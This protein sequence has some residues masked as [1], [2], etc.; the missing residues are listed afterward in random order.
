[1]DLFFV[2]SGFL[3]TRILLYTRGTPEYFKNFYGRRS[4]RIFPLYFGALF[5]VFVVTPWLTGGPV[6][7]LRQQLWYWFY[8]N[9]IAYTFNITAPGPNHFWSL[10]VEEHFYLVWPLLVALLPLGKLKRAAFG[11]IAVAVLTRILLLQADYGVFY[12][13]LSRVDALSAGCLL[14]V[15]ERERSLGTK[16]RAFAYLGPV[17][18]VLLGTVWFGI[19]GGALDWVQVV[20]F[21]LIA[22]TFMCAIGWLL[23]APRD[24]LI[25]RLLSTRALTFTGTISYGLYVIHPFV[26]SAVLGQSVPGGAIGEFIL[27]YSLS[28]GLAYSVYH[29][30]E[31]PFLS[32]KRYFEAG[33]KAQV[34]MPGI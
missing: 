7:H 16:K 34:E 25:V 5:L 19:G 31:K 22:L 21:T 10:A 2:L 11:L 12:F 27:A 26:F 15:W 18:G 17:V 9:N 23:L 32:L 8:V 28:F 4:V 30:Y 3:I 29:L 20:K 1:M 6:V 24:S 33:R 13:T 14:A